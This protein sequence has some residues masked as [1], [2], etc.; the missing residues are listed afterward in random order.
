MDNDLMAR[1]LRP[2]SEPIGWAPTSRD[3]QADGRVADAAP[4]AALEWPSDFAAGNQTETPDVQQ[5][6][7]ED[8]A[9][10]ASDAPWDRPADDDWLAATAAMAATSAEDAAPWDRPSEDDEATDSQA[11]ERPS[12]DRPSDDAWVAAAA[13]EV[14]TQTPVADPY[15]AFAPV[16]ED[17]ARPTTPAWP[18]QNGYAADYERI[19]WPPLAEAADASRP[20]M[21][22]FDDHEPAVVDATPEAVASAPQADDFPAD[23][24]DL[25][26]AAGSPTEF[27]PWMEETENAV[28]EDDQTPSV[29]ADTSVDEWPGS[30]PEPEPL[31][32]VAPSIASD[33]P[34]GPT[35][36]DDLFAEASAAVQDATVDEE[37]VDPAPVANVDETQ[38]LTVADHQPE[39][40]PFL[41]PMVTAAT[42]TT[43]PG[44]PANVVV[45]IEFAIVDGSQRPEGERD[46]LKPRHPEFEPRA[47]REQEAAWDEPIEDADNPA[48]DWVGAWS[49]PTLTWPEGAAVSEPAPTTEVVSAPEPEVEPEPTS[50]SDPWSSA[51]SREGPL[52]AVPSAAP[53]FAPPESVF[54]NPAVPINDPLAQVP[55]APVEPA[56]KAEASSSSVAS[57]A[58]AA[59]HQGTSPDTSDLWFLSSEPNTATLSADGDAAARQSSSLLTGALTVGMAILVVVLVLVFI[60]LMTSILH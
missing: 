30:M 53:E 58:S 11:D 33:L 8:D 26:A 51:T 10:V 54:V 46:L 1:R 28:V 15:D 36:P 35:P 39:A 52:P 29:R 48:A 12:W 34:L 41:V 47:P 6:A 31:P 23:A 22:A 38:S 60:Q 50:R 45:R 13:S 59:G 5:A 14:P 43:S 18:G 57:T 32:S 24:F 3:E 44:N 4:W 21:F 20:A 7:V 37:D 2:P 56:V 17:V 25:P 19:E 16:L 40:A 27:V 42:A 9:S 49:Q 55:A